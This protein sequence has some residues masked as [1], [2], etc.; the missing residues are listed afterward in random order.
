MTCFFRVS[1]LH[2]ARA[3]IR[4]F[5]CSTYIGDFCVDLQ[6]IIIAYAVISF[7]RLSVFPQYIRVYINIHVYEPQELVIISVVTFI[8]RHANLRKKK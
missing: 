2:V 1:F 5:C 7:I 4:L 3:Q 8:R 6:S